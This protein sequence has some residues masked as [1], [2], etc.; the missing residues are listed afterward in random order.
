ML[1]TENEDDFRFARI[2]R[3]DAAVRAIP[4][5]VQLFDLAARDVHHFNRI[6]GKIGPCLVRASIVNDPLA[7]GGP[8]A[9]VG[10]NTAPGT[11]GKLAL[12]IACRSTKCV[13][14]RINA[15][16]HK[17]ENNGQPSDSSETQSHV[18]A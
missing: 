13:V 4:G 3:N 1:R 5:P 15:G 9:G 2:E 12:G 14:G 10:K 17:Q 7:V 6:A 8:N 18:L 11:S 16:C